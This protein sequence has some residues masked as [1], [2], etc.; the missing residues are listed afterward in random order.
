MTY[1]LNALPAM[2][3][4]HGKMNVSWGNLYE[5]V[6]TVLREMHAILSR[7][8]AFGISDGQAH[9]I[10]LV[11]TRGRWSQILPRNSAREHQ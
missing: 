7:Q 3:N 5:H 1:Y 8:Y 6:F 2:Q 9:A 10:P 4:R 11:L